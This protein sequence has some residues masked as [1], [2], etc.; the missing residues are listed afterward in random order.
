MKL[1]GTHERLVYADDVNV[2]G[3]SVRTVK[4]NTE[5]FL[6]ASKETGLKVS[7]DK[8]KY[9]IMSR[10]QNVGQSHTTKTGNRSFESVEE[11]KY[12]RTTLTEQNSIQE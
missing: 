8:S 9:M 10:N 11:F 3:G 4:E 2:L 5:A 6:V 7:A 12:M 1:N